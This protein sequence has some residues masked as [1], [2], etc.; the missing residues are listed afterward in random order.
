MINFT[1]QNLPRILG[2][3]YFYLLKYYFKYS[4]IKEPYINQGL[5]FNYLHTH[6]NFSIAQILY[7]F[8]KF[9]CKLNYL[10]YLLLTDHDYLCFLY[11]VF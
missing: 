7:K 5:Y 2:K 10:K 11:S 8:A 3:K 1:F 9:T 4:V 6:Q